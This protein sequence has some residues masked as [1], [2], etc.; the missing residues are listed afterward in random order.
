MTHEAR[1]DAIRAA[2]AALHYARL[3][4]P[5]TA[6]GRALLAWHLNEARRRL[7]VATRD[8]D[9]TR[10]GCGARSVVRGPRPGE[11]FCG[12]C[13]NERTIDGR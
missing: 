11:F 1:I 12:H 5:K 2:S 7:D 4:D 13:W 6:V 10:C 3:A 8:L 9:R